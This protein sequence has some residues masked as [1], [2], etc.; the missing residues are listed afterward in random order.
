MWDFL[1]NEIAKLNQQSNNGKEEERV[2]RCRLSAG[3]PCPRC[4]KGKLDYN[5]L[6]NL[7]CP[8]C[9]YELTASFT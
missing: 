4:G 6:L 9:K 5:S 8:V 2:Q 1:D 3:Q 7:T